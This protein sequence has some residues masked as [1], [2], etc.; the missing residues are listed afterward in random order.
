MSTENQGGMISGEESSCF[1]YQ[2]SLAILIAQSS[3]NILGK[4]S[5]K[6]MMNLS[7]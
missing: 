5:R 7:L 3:S 1:V 4:T 2:S 6:K